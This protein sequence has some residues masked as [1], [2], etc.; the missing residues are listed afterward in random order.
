M[1][2]LITVLLV[3]VVATPASAG[4]I[5]G[6]KAFRKAEYQLASDEF[7]KAKEQE[8]AEDPEAHPQPFRAHY[9]LGMSLARL[10]LTDEA[11]AELKRGYSMNNGDP[12]AQAAM[13]RARLLGGDARRTAILLDGVD[14]SDLSTAD[15]GLFYETRGRLRLDKGRYP[16]AV[17]DLEKASRF[18]PHHWPILR[19]LGHGYRMTDRLIAAHTVL[20]KALAKVPEGGDAGEIWIEMGRTFEGQ[21]KLPEAADAFEKAG[22]S[23]IAARLRGIPEEEE[24]PVAAAEPAPLSP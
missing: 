21:Q 13:A 23:E 8:P 6:I 12:G 2:K 20:E 3:L 14:P 9:M 11:I 22:E 18:L 17:T 15:R 24:E 4:W 1:G 10:Q 5:E 7:R 19:Y 16:E